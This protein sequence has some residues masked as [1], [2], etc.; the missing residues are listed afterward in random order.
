MF[1]LL[2]SQMVKIG[3]IL[4]AFCFKILHLFSYHVISK[5][6]DLRKTALNK[7]QNHCKWRI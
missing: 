7:K 6:M 5:V 4:F 2:I 3:H 1:N